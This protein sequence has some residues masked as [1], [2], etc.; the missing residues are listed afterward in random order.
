MNKE[1]LQKVL[2]LEIKIYFAAYMTY[3][4]KIFLI[5]LLTNAV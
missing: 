3:F 2:L 5:L 1:S 4:S